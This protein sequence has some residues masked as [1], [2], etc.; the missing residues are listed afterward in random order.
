MGSYFI[1]ARV[2]L[3]A[4]TQLSPMARKALSS[5]SGAVDIALFLFFK[6]SFFSNGARLGC[7]FLG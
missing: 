5:A 7:T 3:V 4:I 2:A 6:L 1:M